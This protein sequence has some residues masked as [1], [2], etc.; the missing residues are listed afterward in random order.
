MVQDDKFCTCMTFLSADAVTHR[1]FGPD[2]WFDFDSFSENPADVAA[3]V[4]GAML[5][6]MW[7]RVLYP[8]EPAP[9]EY[10]PR[11]YV[12]GVNSPD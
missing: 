9:S 1:G 12:E 7:G 5:A 10:V 3:A 4:A 8:T 6:S 2:V 11:L